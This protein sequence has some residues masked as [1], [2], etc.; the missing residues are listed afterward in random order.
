VLE[1]EVRA[2]VLSEPA[3]DLHAPDVLADRVVAA[4]LRDQHAVSALETLDAQRPAD[5]FGQVALEPGHQDRERRHRH[6]ARHVRRHLEEGLGVGH[7]QRRR[8]RQPC[9]R[10]PQLALLRHQRHRLAVQQV[11]DGHDLWEDQAALRRLL[12]DG[13]D[14][15]GHL[16]GRHQIRHQPAVVEEVG[17]RQA[18]QRLAHV[19]D[20]GPRGGGD[21][22]PRNA[23]LLEPLDLG[24][25]RRPQVRLVE[26]DEHRDA[27]AGQ[28]R[29]Q[30]LLERAPSAG[31][32]DDDAEVHAVEHR[33][34]AL[35]AQ[36]PERPLVVHARR[37]HEEHGAERQQ[38]HRLLDR[39]G[40][41][42]RKRRHDR[43]LLPGDGVQQGRL[44]DVAAAEDADVQSE[45]L[46]R[47]VHLTKALGSRLWAQAAGRLSARPD[48]RRSAPIPES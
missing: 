39:V 6:V 23:R 3:R 44:A 32:R 34:G 7:H 1:L 13:H 9:K 5:L 2:H 30:R 48:A 11:A 46:G 37:V 18:Q 43:H 25:S 22:H 31:L 42:A 26:D 17:R 12:V 8:P 20:P 4:R 33:L 10:V 38:L 16:T 19:E 14:Q 41:R 40:G 29:D 36:L 21:H 24:G 35:D 27:A 15:D 45:R 28:L 47:G